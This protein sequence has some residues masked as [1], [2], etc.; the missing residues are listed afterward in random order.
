MGEIAANGPWIVAQLVRVRNLEADVKSLLA[1]SNT[2]G[3][4]LKGRMAEL[5]F[6]LTLLELAVN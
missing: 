1:A 4:V 5:N 6:Q 2:P 3:S